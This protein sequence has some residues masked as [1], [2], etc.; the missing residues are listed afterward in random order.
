MP[1]GDAFNVSRMASRTHD[2]CTSI[3]D[4]LG[5]AVLAV[6]VASD[7]LDLV[8]VSAPAANHKCSFQEAHAAGDDRGGP[9]EPAEKRQCG[10]R[11]EATQ[12]GP[13]CQNA[14]ALKHD[15]ISFHTER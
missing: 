3:V 11:G 6:M 4:G 10:R 9:D 8:V 2:V 14:F 1:P 12:Y 15:S 5:V 13:T 7:V